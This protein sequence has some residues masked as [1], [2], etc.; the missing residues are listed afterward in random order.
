MV[1]KCFK[2]F[3]FGILQ[4]LKISNL[5]NKST[6]SVY[7]DITRKLIECS[8]KSFLLTLTVFEILLFKSRSVL[9]AAGVKGARGF[10][11]SLE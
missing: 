6:K 7:S 1:F 11:R 5:R 10:K 3:D 8:L 2:F 4:T 9:S